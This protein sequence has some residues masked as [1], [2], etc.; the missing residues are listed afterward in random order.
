VAGLLSPSL[1][2]PLEPE[3]PRRT[4]RP[5]LLIKREA[6]VLFHV[7]AA[8]PSR[9]EEELD[10]DLQLEAR[11]VPRSGPRRSYLLSGA[12]RTSLMGWRK[13]PLLPKQT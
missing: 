1:V 11:S 3:K 4:P 13:C 6:I 2:P 5:G 10:A 9:R 12:Q 7:A 8:L